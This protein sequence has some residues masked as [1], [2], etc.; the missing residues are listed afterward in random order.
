MF[1]RS[2]RVI[3]TVPID[4]AATR[5][6][7]FVMRRAIQDYRIVELFEKSE[8]LKM[9]NLTEALRSGKQAD[10]DG[11]VC[12]VSRQACH[13]AA[14][15]I[16]RLERVVEEIWKSFYGQNLEVANWHQNGEFEPMDSFFESNDWSAEPST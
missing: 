10:E 2:R 14:D 15:R 4:V 9:S 1:N 12:V 5:L 11:V 8:R 7:H 6:Q 3:V 16:D 13:E